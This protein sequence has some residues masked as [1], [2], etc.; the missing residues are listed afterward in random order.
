MSK[1]MFRLVALLAAVASALAVL[2]ISLAGGAKNPRWPISALAQKH[3]RARLAAAPPAVLSGDTDVSLAATSGTNSLYVSHEHGSSRDCVYDHI[4]SQAG[5]GNGINAG[6]A[7]SKGA[8]STFQA[9]G[10]TTRVLALVPDGVRSLSVTSLDGS[11]H[12]V[13]VVNNVAIAEV[14]APASVSYELP[15]GSL[16]TRDVRGWTAPLSTLKPSPP[17]SSE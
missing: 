15:D 9:E 1:N 8:I 17:G 10:E 6:I 4:S 2:G 3:S 16:Q 14:A 7:E 12:I 5:G 13:T 11:A